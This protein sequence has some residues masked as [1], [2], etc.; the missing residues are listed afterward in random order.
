ML[1]ISRYIHC[2]CVAAGC[3][4]CTANNPLLIAF[5][6]SGNS[7]SDWHLTHIFLLCFSLFY[8]YTHILAHSVFIT[9]PFSSGEVLTTFHF[10]KLSQRI[11]NCHQCRR[12]VCNR[13]CI[14]DTVNSHK[15]RENNNQ[16]QK[17][18]HLSC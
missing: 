7:P 1:R 11:S 3:G 12:C 5:R 10:A 2:L 16:R 14:H 6:P 8:Y 17:E 15:N 4:T 18:N 13:S 9:Q